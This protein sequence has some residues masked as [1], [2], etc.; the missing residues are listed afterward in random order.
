ML[1]L[2]IETSCDETAVALLKA[3]NGR[4][5]IISN[6]VFSQI[7]IH[8]KYGGI[9]PETAAR[10]HIETILPLLGQCLKKSECDKKTIKI[11][12]QS[13]G[14]KSPISFSPKIDCIAVTNGPGLITSL[15]VG[16]ETAKALS[17]VWQKPLVNVNHLEGHIYA[18]WLT[19]IDEI[20]NHKFQ[21]P[22]IEFPALCLI[23]SGGHTELV[24]MKNHGQYK[25]IGETLDDAAGECFDKVAKLLEI[26]YPGGPII[27]QLAKNGNPH[28]FDLPRPMIKSGNYNFSFSGLKTAVLYKLQGFHP[29][30]S[31]RGA[32]LPR[33]KLFNRVKFRPQNFL[34]DF[35]ASF[36][37]AVIDVLLE[38][39]IKAAKEYKVKSIVLG[40]GVAANKELRKQ[41]E[42]KVKK[43]L[44][45]VNLFIPPLE[46]CTDNAAMIAAAAYFHILKNNFS[47]WKK[48]KVDPNL[49]F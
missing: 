20:P 42:E 24:L 11:S 48:S 49:N 36:Q 34:P 40:G 10:K 27:S 41:F 39:T 13:K 3:E 9:V 7:E 18:N 26:G 8:K 4:F 32:I 28:A 43:E 30:K 33:A 47:D 17:Y 44:C 29:V 19:P 2:A 25:K 6:L 5:E 14:I 22:K 23:V 45:G 46:F 16:V 1:I 38:K 31:P 35:C 12:D 37:Q 15:L 21:N